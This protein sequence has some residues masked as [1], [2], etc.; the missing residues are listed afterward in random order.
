MIKM[1]GKTKDYRDEINEPHQESMLHELKHECW[2]KVCI[3]M[4]N[5]SNFYEVLLHPH[6]SA[7]TM[8]NSWNWVPR[9]E[10]N[11]MFSNMAKDRVRNNFWLGHTDACQSGNQHGTEQYVSF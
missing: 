9:F 2:V 7:I 8:P 11:Y 6:P 5:S 4:L 10:I 1:D 3:K